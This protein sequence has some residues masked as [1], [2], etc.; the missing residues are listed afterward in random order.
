MSYWLVNGGAMTWLALVGGSE[1][2]Q[3]TALQR[4]LLYLAPGYSA[5]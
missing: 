4:A 1:A 2:G 3:V 5:I